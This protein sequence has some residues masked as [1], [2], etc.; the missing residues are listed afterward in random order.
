VL[1]QWQ[2][3]RDGGLACYE[4]GADAQDDVVITNSP[5]WTPAPATYIDVPAAEWNHNTSI[6]IWLAVEN[7][8]S[9]DPDVAHGFFDDIRLDVVGGVDDVIFADGFDP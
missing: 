9:A 1:M 5:D 6:E 2:Y 8:G 4:G 3:R 7:S